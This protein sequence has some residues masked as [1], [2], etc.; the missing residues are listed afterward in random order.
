MKRRFVSLLLCLYPARWRR[1]YGPELEEMLLREPLGLATVLNLLWS[2][3]R[4]QLRTGEPWLIIGLPLL[5]LEFV[6]LALADSGRYLPGAQYLNWVAR[7]LPL[8]IGG[9]TAARSGKAGR[10]GMKFALLLYVPPLLNHHRPP[11]PYILSSVVACGIAAWL[12]SLPVLAA[13][14]LR[15]Y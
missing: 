12:G 8:L 14:K 11:F 10:A 2:G 4:Q 1:E 6:A 9:W 3:G 13:R 7:C 5:A 15:R